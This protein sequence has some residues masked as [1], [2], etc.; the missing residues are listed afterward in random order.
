[1][2]KLFLWSFF[3]FIFLFQHSFAQKISPVGLTCEYKK[4]PLGIDSQSPRLSWLIEAGSQR[5]ILQT[6]YEIRVSKTRQGLGNKADL[7]WE[8]GKINSSQSIQIEY[9]GKGLEPRQKYYWQVKIYTNKDES[10]WSEIN[11]WETG[12][13]KPANWQAQWIEADIKE[14]VGQAQPAQYFRK[15]FSTKEK[16]ISARAYITSHGLYEASINGKKIGD[17][18]FTPGWTTYKKRLQYQVYDVTNLLQTGTNAIGVVLG[19]GWFRGSLAWEKNRNIFGKT[20]GLIMEIELTYTSGKKENIFTDTSWKYNQGPILK[21]EIYNGE[22]Y[23][24]RLEKKGWDLLGFADKDWTHVKNANIGKTQ[25]TATD[26]PLVKK[27]EE[28][29]PLKIIFTPKGDTII[30]F[31][32]NMTGWIKLKVSGRAGTKVLVQHAEVLDKKGNFY[33]ENLR[34]AAAKLEYTLKGGGEEV[35]E[36]HFTFMGFRYAAVHGFPGKISLN[37]FTGIVIHSD[38]EKTGNFECANPQLNQLQHNIQWGQKGN[39]LD[40]PT[41]CPQRDERLGWTGDAEVFAPTASFNFNVA[42]FFTKW[43]KDVAADQLEDGSVPA[44]IPDVLNSNDIAAACGWA[45]VSTIVPFVMYEHFGDKRILEVQYPSMKAWVELMRKKAGEKFIINSGFHFG[46]WLYYNTT[47]PGG[48]AAYTDKDLLA[49][50]FFAYSSSILSKSATIIGKEEESK[51]YNTLFENI[52]KAF[53]KEFVTNEARLSPNTQ[54][55]YTLALVFGLLPEGQRLKAAERL[56]ADI[57]QRGNHISTGFLG[58]PHIARALSEN[59]Q[60]K[61]AYDLLLQDTYPSWL[62]PVKM[63]ATT[64]WERWDGIKQDSTFQDKGMNSFNHYAYGAIGDW[65]YQN[66]GG[67]KLDEKVPAYKHFLI[68]PM[69][70]SRIPSSKTSLVSPYGKISTDWK[71]QNGNFIISITVPANT[72]AEATLPKAKTHN[73]KE[74][75][76]PIKN[77]NGITE[78][79]SVNEGIKL[80]LGSGNYEFTYPFAF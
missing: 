21:S 52:K 36:P 37:N 71:I 31:G 20:L 16:I 1:M 77:G 51:E 8:S 46:D 70:D 69:P 45:D 65:M 3:F 73:V 55:A 10:N 54:T 66:M 14:D 78:I 74:K 62:F 44:V 63:G 64:I 2:K 34:N 32:Q 39:F 13:F 28:I 60:L 30:D 33:T 53:Q 35:F 59:G 79:Q 12:L 22:I 67:I 80:K 26:G 5:D 47:D 24:A 43:M 4:N 11:F 58:T 68:Q 18:L 27:I 57:K 56:A 19:E 29:K 41:D 25:I 42:S 48:A 72:T 75:N 15:E 17:G 50:A 7:I 9:G 49:T 6:A 23:D 38:M 61:V 40:V 76:N